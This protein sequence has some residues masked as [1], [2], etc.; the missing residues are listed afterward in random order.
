MAS[1]HM[2]EE[3]RE[4]NRV[5]EEGFASSRICKVYIGTREQLQGEP[6]IIVGMCQQLG[7]R[8]VTQQLLKNRHPTAAAA[9][10]QAGAL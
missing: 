5:H 3:R 1:H 4:D 2:L 7:L 6:L 9:L 8:T 10:S